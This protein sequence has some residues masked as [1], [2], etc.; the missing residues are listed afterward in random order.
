MEAVTVLAA[1]L[2]AVGILGL[3]VPVLPGLAVTILGVLVWALDRQETAAW[4]VLGVCVLIAL[5]GWTLQYLIPGRRMKAQGVPTSVLMIGALCGLVGFFVIP[6]LGLPI[7]FV[8]GVYV[9]EHLR[10]KESAAARRQT[11]LAL[12]GVMLSIGIELAAA[13]MV[14]ATW[15]VGLLVTR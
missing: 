12:K 4:V 3:V 8:A 5:A 11:V 13:L 9:A 6:V 7:G 14:A 10:L 2:I 1:V 15:V